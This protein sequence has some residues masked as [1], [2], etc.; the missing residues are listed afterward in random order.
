MGKLQKNSLLLCLFLWGIWT[1]GCGQQTQTYEHSAVVM[2]TVVTLSA[3][4]T[5]AK[6]AVEESFERLQNLEDMCSSHIDTS[7]AAKLKAAAGKDYVRLHPE[8]WH[9][10]MV[11]QEYSERSGGAWDITTG[12]LVE[13]WGIG[14]DQA[15]VPTK[16]EIQTARQLV[17]WQ[18]LHLNAA[19]Q[20]AM[21]E[22]PG[23]SIDLGGIAKGMAVDEVR[24]IYAAHGI[25]D[26]LINMGSSSM[27]ALGKNKDGKAWNI[28][29]KHPRSEDKSAYLGIVSLQDEALSTSGDYER[30]F[31]QDGQRY[32]HILDPHTGY[33]AY[34]GAMS[35]TIIVAGS[36]EDAGM[37]SDLLTTAVF[38]LGPQ[39]GQIFLQQLPDAIQG[40]IT[41]QQFELFTAHGFSK[42]IR[43]LDKNFSFVTEPPNL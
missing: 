31:L 33:P 32:H 34:R 24:K 8:V 15:R 22:Q 1:A 28:G 14:T 11:S 29:I 5:E 36:V 16:E 13:L 39:Q 38:V 25:R 3:S 21:L 6:A 10:L 17:G 12:P 20:S 35:D 41:S 42:R 18:K 9:M 30:F 7:D 23:M 2:D 26:G 19:E 4:G 43:E 40:E 37:L 27:Y